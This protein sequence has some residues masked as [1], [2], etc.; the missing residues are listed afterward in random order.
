M[1]FQP[2]TFVLAL[3]CVAAV[4]AQTTQARNDEGRLAELI[5]RLHDTETFAEAQ[6]ELIGMG[7]PAV[8]A[9]IQALASQRLSSPTPLLQTLGAMGADAV[10]AVPEL[11]VALRQGSQRTMALWA[12]G[13]VG[14]WASDRIEIGEDI[15]V[16]LESSA[17]FFR[18]EL[19]RTLSRLS[20]DPRASLREL[21]QELD[22]RN[23][24]T[25]QFV[26][27]L[28]G[29][30]RSGGEAAEVLLR[31]LDTEN[32]PGSVPRVA[33][34][35]AS[36]SFR[37]REYSAGMDDQIRLAAATSLLELIP[38]DPAAI[39]AYLVLLDCPDPEVRRKAAMALGRQ[40]ALGAE[41]VPKLLRTTLDRDLR[42]VAEAVTALGMIGPQAQ[43][44]IPKLE[45]LT[46]HDNKQ[47]AERA[48]VA[49]RQ[50]RR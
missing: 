48:R 9:L 4:P 8:P 14:P 22:N 43:L 17:D 16:A 11:L 20:M 34:F 24:F 6:A 10:A 33:V 19:G 28:L 29:D 2:K 27:E 21:E 3:L 42:L 1:R 35:S 37:V 31:I 30:R 38:E 36:A 15:L 47:I 7:S 40:G 32:L 39:P 5:A 13:Q 45:A 44:A 12:L 41:A 25:W 50:I 46:D 23:P 26:A 49:L 18:H